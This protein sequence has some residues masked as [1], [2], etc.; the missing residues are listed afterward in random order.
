ML[1]KLWEKLEAERRVIKETPI[2]FATACVTASIIAVVLCY[3]AFSLALSLKD[4]TIK[5]Y[6][7]RYGDL[8]ALNDDNSKVYVSQLFTNLVDGNRATL[9][10]DPIASTIRIGGVGTPYDF[11]LDFFGTLEGRTIVLN[12]EGLRNF[13]G[14]TNTGGVRFEYVKKTSVR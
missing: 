12:K 13:G 3:G 6:K 11:K 2:H 14:F 1:D 4:A 8:S 9:T 10:H 7:D 5:A